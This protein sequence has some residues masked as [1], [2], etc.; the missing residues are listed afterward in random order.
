MLYLRA[1]AYDTELGRFTTRDPL[2]VPVVPGQV[3]NPY[4]YASNDPLNV[5]DPRGEWPSIPFVSSIVHHVARG[6]DVARHDVAHSVD[7]ARHDVAHQLD[8]I[9]LPGTTLGLN[10][11]GH[12]VVRGLDVARHDVAS[13]FDAARHEIA[14]GLD[15]ARH[16]LAHGFDVA[17]H[18]VAHGFDVARHDTW[19]YLKRHDKVLGKI[20]DVLGDVSAVLAIAGLAIAPIPVLDF[21]TPFL[22][23]GAGITAGLA[24]GFSLTAK[25][26]G[27]RDVSDTDLALD[28]FGAVTFGVGSGAEAAVDS[29]REARVAAKEAGDFEK[30]GRILV[31]EMRNARLLR[32]ADWWA[33]KAVGAAALGYGAVRRHLRE[34][35]P[36]SAPAGPAPRLRRGTAS[37][38]VPLTT[39]STA[40]AGTPVTIVTGSRP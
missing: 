3:V 23:G 10:V 27:N 22:E 36:W 7:A 18:Y 16:D 34:L 14:R 9:H 32:D 35:D 8:S 21:L 28:L 19:A 17:R 12:E 40:A 4:A 38:W 25:L 33:D 13:S 24:F 39:M 1:R 29:L 5:T 6:L 31:G 37:A 20:G 2:A 15:V 30:A 26:A 11:L